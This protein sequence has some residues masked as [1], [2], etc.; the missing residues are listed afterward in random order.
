MDMMQMQDVRFM[1]P[2]LKVETSM[3]LNKAMQNMGIKSAFTSAADFSGIAEMGPLVLDQVKQK[4]YI[5]I[6]EKGTE[7]A[8]VTS[9]QIRL[10]SVRPVVKVPEMRVDRPFVFV[11][12]DGENM[13]ILFA[14]KIV[15]L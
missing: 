1:M 12:A 14:G 9:A 4:C 8:A 5:D 11:I 2:R 3:I 15:N 10:T 7:A 6:S 13:N